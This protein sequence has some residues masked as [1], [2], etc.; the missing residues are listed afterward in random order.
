MFDLDGNGAVDKAEF[1]HVIEHV[2]R[3]IAAK[4]GQTDLAISAE[5][6]IRR[7][8]SLTV[9]QSP[10]RGSLLV[11]NSSSLLFV[12]IDTLPRLTKHLFGHFT[13]TITAQELKAA[14]D[15]LRKHILRAEFDLYATK[16]QKLKNQEAVSVHDFA[17]TLI[18]GFD[19]DKLPPFLERV[20]EL[21]ASDVS[22]ITRC[23]VGGAH[24]CKS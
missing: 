10:L 4:E 18:S 21:N 20:L 5:G 14:L 1:C 3:V 22:S 12:F 19:P 6:I 9:M 2:L 13:K 24:F 7:A 11:T 23:G 8:I 15:L 17:V 16:R